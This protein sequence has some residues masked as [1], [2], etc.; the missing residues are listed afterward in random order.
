MNRN[1]VREADRA[2]IEEVAAETAGFLEKHYVPGF[3]V[4]P[5]ADPDSNYYN[6]VWARDFANA[7]GNYFGE[8]N[9][10]AVADSLQTILKYQLPSGELPLRVERE[11]QRIKF[12]PFF[13][14][15]SKQIFNF[16]EGRVHGR[17]ERPVYEGMDAAGGEDTAP[18]VIIAAAEYFFSS[19]AGESFGREQFDELARAADFFKLKTDPEDGLAVMTHDNPDWVDTVRR[20]GKLGAINIWWARAL[21]YL[22]RMASALGREADAEKYGAEFAK[23][24]ASVITKLYD[25]EGACFRAKAGENRLDTVA[26]IFGALYFLDAEEAARMEATLDRRVR[27]PTGLQNFDPPY[28]PSDLFWLHRMLGAWRYHNEYVWPWVT[29]QNIFVKLK[30]GA[31]H[32]EK[33]VRDQ[34]RHEAVRDLKLL[35]RIFKE[36]GAAYEVIHADT[37]IAPR[38][39]IYRVPERFMGSMVAFHGAY[40]RLKK[41]GWI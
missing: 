10:Q 27:K 28:P 23:V 17:S 14:R 20:H 12:L 39:L 6:Q 21:Q 35:A 26:C 33:A 41:I 37:G 30:I 13:R 4:F 2:L 24:K 11:Y 29:A 36:T 15:W 3:G 34:Y 9:P 5:S 19:S 31:R 18:L 38:H 7:A 8:K 16:I 1:D 40:L 32:K 25:A 22:E